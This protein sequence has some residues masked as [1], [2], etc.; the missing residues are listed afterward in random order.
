LPG[1]EY[2]LDLGAGAGAVDVRGVAHDPDADHAVV[3]HVGAGSIDVEGDD[4][5]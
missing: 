2:R 3:L 5:W 1:G 4:L